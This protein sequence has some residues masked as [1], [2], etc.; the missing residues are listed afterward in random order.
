[1]KNN[2]NFAYFLKFV[3]ENSNFFYEKNI[4]LEIKKKF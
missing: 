2:P 1:M 3:E 4:F